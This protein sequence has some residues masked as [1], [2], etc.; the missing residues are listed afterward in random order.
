MVMR[1]KINNINPIQIISNLRKSSFPIKFAFFFLVFVAIVYS[2]S[3]QLKSGERIDNVKTN[4][5]EE[6]LEIQFSNGTKITIP[7]SEILNH[8][9]LPIQSEKDLKKENIDKKPVESDV[10]QSSEQ[11]KDSEK[12]PD[13]SGIVVKGEKDKDIGR[14]SD[15]HG[16]NIFYGKKNEVILP[17]K[18]NANLAVNMNRQLYA[19]VPGIM[20]Q[21]NDGTGIQTSIA[22]RGLNPNRSW[23][24]NTRQN[25]YD[26]SADL[27]DILKPIIRRRLKQW[28]ELKL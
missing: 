5:M 16:T 15:I 2:D 12:K 26:I 19:K 9:V 17:D 10:K 21:E 4:A 23:E 6:S 22:V 20:V 3:I 25:G 7:K 8:E 27:W 13:T 11:P 24:F 1:I 28:K 18:A 14:L